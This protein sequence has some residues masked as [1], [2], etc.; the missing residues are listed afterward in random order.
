MSDL[1]A[2]AAAAGMQVELQDVE[3]LSEGAPESVAVLGVCA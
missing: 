2:A 3:M 1:L